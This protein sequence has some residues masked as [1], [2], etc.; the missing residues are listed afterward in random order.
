M[1][2]GQLVLTVVVT[3][4]IVD[5]VG[6][7]LDALAA[8]DASAWLPDPVLLV[9]ASVVLLRR[10]LPLGVALGTPGA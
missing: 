8:Q 5:R 6:L 9:A 3:W 4:L 10:V 1:R 7:G 2:L